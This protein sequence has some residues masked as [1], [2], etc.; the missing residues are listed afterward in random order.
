[1]KVKIT[2]KASYPR[3]VTYFRTNR[4][5]VLDSKESIT[6]NIKDPVEKAFYESL[7]NSGF[8]VEFS[9][10]GEGSGDSLFSEFSDDDLKRIVK[11]L[12]IST[13]V[14]ARWKLERLIQ[15][16][17]GDALAYGVSLKDYL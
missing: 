3:E 8:S 1:M 2:N 15:G 13:G 12:G 11:N 17:L 14:R 9:Q 10:E 4:T 5:T 16:N 7:G 6:V